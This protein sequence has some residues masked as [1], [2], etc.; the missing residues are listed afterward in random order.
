MNIS[1]YLRRSHLLQRIKYR[2]RML[3]Y[4]SQRSRRI[5]S[6]SFVDATVQVLGWHSVSIG[7]NSVVS[8]YCTINVNHYGAVTDTVRIGSNVWIAKRNFFSPGDLIELAD[9][10]MTAPDCHFL[11]TNHVIGDPLRPYISTGTTAGGRIR[12]G[13]NCWVGARATI[14]ADVDIGHGSIIG[15]GATVRSSIPPYS[16]AV[17]TPA[18]V[19]RRF[20][21]S[22]KEWVRP[23][24]LS[25]EDLSLIPSETEYLLILRRSHPRVSMPLLAA[26]RSMG[27]YY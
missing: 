17:G 3:L 14:F 2:V 27:D 22:R 21:P 23:E 19:V 9:Y 5:G 13:T 1:Q 16:M 24:E 25:D 20:S 10:V 11:G 7:Q 4:R 6:G 26:G 18:R 8:E 12:I 15:A